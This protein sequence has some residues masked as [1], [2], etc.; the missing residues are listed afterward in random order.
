MA[1]NKKDMA[2]LL[3][4]MISK[5]EPTDETPTAQDGEALAPDILERLDVS[6]E[7]AE[8]LSKKRYKHVGRPK[9]T[10][11]RKD[12]NPYEIRATFVTD[13]RVIRKLKYIALSDT[14][15]FKDVVT[16]ALSEYVSQWENTNEEIN[17]K[18][19]DV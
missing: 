11:K 19:K 8:A 2:S 9:G 14:R 4:K 7:L 5:P 18:S 13:A 1:T 6:P 10:T 16:E 17:L 3:N 12:P 15:L